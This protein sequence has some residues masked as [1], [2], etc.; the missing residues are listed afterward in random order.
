MTPLE[1]AARRVVE[2]MT[3]VHT[4]CDPRYM[5]DLQKSVNALEAALDAAP[6]QRGGAGQGT[7]S[8]PYYACDLKMNHTG[9]CQHTVEPAP[10]QPDAVDPACP[11]CKGRGHGW[12][13]A[14]LALDEIHA[15]AHS[16]ND[17]WTMR[18][19]RI[20]GQALDAAPT[21]Q[22]G[23]VTEQSGY[24]NRDPCEAPDCLAE[25]CDAVGCNGHTIDPDPVMVRACP[26]CDGKGL[27]LI[28]A[29]GYFAVATCPTCHHA[30]T[31]EPAPP[32]PT[33]RSEK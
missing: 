7:G 31:V 6:T 17:G 15:E 26:R 1:Q 2:D 21:Q 9:P 33:E 23:A 22:G 25:G 5:R 32:Q 30:P 11:E 13:A 4:D 20:I 29:G 10:P 8:C 24:D 19:I 3:W 28:N 16:R 12:Q 14:N 18:R 27:A